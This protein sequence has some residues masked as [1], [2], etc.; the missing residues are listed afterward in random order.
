MK[1]GERNEVY[2]MSATTHPDEAAP[3]FP[4]LQLRCIEGQ[5]NKNW[6]YPLCGA[7]GERVGQ[8][9]VAGVSRCQHTKPITWVKTLHVITVFSR[10]ILVSTRNDD[11]FIYFQTALKKN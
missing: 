3:V 1:F 2:R 5:K 7:A 6:S 8:R 11:L 9:S 10:I 4:S